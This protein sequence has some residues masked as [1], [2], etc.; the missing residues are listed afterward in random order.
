[1]LC[2]DFHASD[3]DKVDQG[4]LELCALKL[5]LLVRVIDTYN[6]TILYFLFSNTMYKYMGVLIKLLL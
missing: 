5:C 3:T 1:M 4:L 2:K 6:F